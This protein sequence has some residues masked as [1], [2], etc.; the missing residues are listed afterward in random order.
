TR[1]LRRTSNGEH[2]IACDETRN[3]CSR[4]LSGRPRHDRV[5]VSC[6]VP[7]ET[8]VMAT[9]SAERPPE[10]ELA[11][12]PAKDYP[13]VRGNRY[14]RLHAGWSWGQ[15]GEHLLPDRARHQCAWR[16]SLL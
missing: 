12:V 3:V 6:R 9:A 5:L 4:V 15:H 13:D 8:G 16:C 10:H 7:P 11:A 14:A 2:Y 1:C